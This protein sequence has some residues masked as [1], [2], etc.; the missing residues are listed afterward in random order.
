M[1]RPTQKELSQELLRLIGTP[2]LPIGSHHSERSLAARFGVS[3]TPLRSALQ[4][5]AE[6]GNVML[7]GRRGWAIMSR[8][9][10]GR[11]GPARDPE[12]DLGFRLC[13][14]R[15]LG[16]LPQAISETELIKRYDTTR[17][18]LQ[19]ALAGLVR[20]GMIERSRGYGWRFLPMLDDQ[21]SRIASYDLRIAIEPAAI[22]AE[23]FSIDRE[24]LADLRERHDNLLA[25]GLAS[26]SARVLFE[27]NADFHLMLVEMSGNEFF[28]E[29]IGRQNQLRRIVEYSTQVDRER[30]RQSCL[31]HLAIIDALE[32]GDRNWAATLME[33]HLKAAKTLLQP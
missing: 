33:R 28:V 6:T 5:L 24:R 15:F 18:E 23:T 11:D 22:L 31:E 19:R 17:G 13:R 8:G 2:E 1:S 4:D 7:D 12:A 16:M 25:G 26:A 3:R 14:D 27:A 20:D 9:M 29:A 30:M 10:E 32:A 21:R